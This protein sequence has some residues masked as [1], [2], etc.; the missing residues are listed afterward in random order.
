MKQLLGERNLK[1]LSFLGASAAEP[2]S[3]CSN[4][5]LKTKTNKQ[6]S[7]PLPGAGAHTYY[8]ILDIDDVYIKN[9]TYL[10]YKIVSVWSSPE[11]GG[12]PSKEPTKNQRKQL[13]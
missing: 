13:L 3:S 10:W 12:F 1:T 7:K 6:Q 2:L 8:L 4:T 9:T 11:L 5:Q